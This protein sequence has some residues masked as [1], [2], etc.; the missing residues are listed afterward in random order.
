MLHIPIQLAF[1][2]NLIIVS[3]LDLI[4]SS[5]SLIFF[6]KESNVILKPT[7]DRT[8]SKKKNNNNNNLPQLC[9]KLSQ[10]LII[11]NEQFHQMWTFLPDFEINIF[12]YNADNSLALFCQILVV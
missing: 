6:L 7:I 4:K 2:S 12:L 3:I 11:Y 9:L 5:F 8:N 10:D 1:I